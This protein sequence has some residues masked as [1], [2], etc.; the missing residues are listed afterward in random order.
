MGALS[1]RADTAQAKTAAFPVSCHDPCSLNAGAV[2]GAPFSA[3]PS[4]C[5]ILGAPLLVSLD[6]RLFGPMDDKQG[7]S[8]VGLGHSEGDVPV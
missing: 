7:T 8:M 2:L 1:S 5:A 6:E 4:R 3:R